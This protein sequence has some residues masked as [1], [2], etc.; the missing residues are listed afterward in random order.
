MH[1]VFSSSFLSILGLFSTENQ[2]L[3]ST[4][5]DSVA[6]HDIKSCSLPSRPLQGDTVWWN[7]IVFKNIRT[8]FEHVFLLPICCWKQCSGHQCS[9]KSTVVRSEDVVSYL[10]SVLTSSVNLDSSLSL[11]WPDFPLTLWGLVSTSAKWGSYLS[12]RNFVRI[13]WEK[14]CE[15]ILKKAK[16]SIPIK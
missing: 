2:S 14:M 6:Y 1:A 13:K 9:G 3:S 4:M 12:Y 8:G 11:F 16:C 15:V 7:F 5:L 10:S